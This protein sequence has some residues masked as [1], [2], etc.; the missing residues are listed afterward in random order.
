M[1]SAAASAFLNDQIPVKQQ[2]LLPPAFRSAYAAVKELV[3]DVPFLKVGSAEFNVGR[4]RTWAVDHA[5]ENLIKSGQWNVDHRWRTFGNPKPT[6]KYLEI[7]LSHSKMTISQ[8]ADPK[9]QP[10]NVR[11][12]ENARLFNHPFLPFEDLKADAEISG[13]PAFLMLHGH[14]DLDFLHAAMPYATRRYGY[15]CRTANLLTLPYEVTQKGPA[16]EDTSF[17]E[18]TIQLKDQIAKWLKDNHGA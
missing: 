8:V 18:S 16:P 17:K 12:R 1:D 4:L 14:Q 9:K 11:F 13:R 5:V 10:R 15:I 7:L 2:V 6:G 3:N